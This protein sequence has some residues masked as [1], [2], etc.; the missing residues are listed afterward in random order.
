MSSPL[1]SP[2][3]HPPDQEADPPTHHPESPETQTLA[4]EA[5]PSRSDGDSQILV[6][7]DDSTQDQPDPVPAPSPSP[8]AQDPSFMAFASSRRRGGPKSKKAVQKRRA[9]A[10]K[11][12]QKLELLVKTFKPVPFAPGKV[13]DF[14]RREGLLQRLGLWEFV[15]LDFDRPLRG[16]LIAQLVASFSKIERCSYVNGVKIRVSRADLARALKLPAKRVV[17]SAEGAGEGSETEESI[18]FVLDL[19]SNW[20]LLHDDDT[21]MM[22]D[23]IMSWDKLIR[24]GSFEKVDWAGM[25]WFMVEK[26]LMLAPNLENCY[27]A[28][29]LQCLIRSQREELLSAVEVEVKD[30]EEVEVKDVD[31]VEVKDLE[32]V[33][34]KDAEE[35]G[36]KDVE[37]DADGGD[38]KMAELEEQ[39]LELSL[40]QEIANN[41]ADEEEKEGNKA[42]EEEKEGASIELGLLQNEKFDVENEDN[43]QLSLGLE[44]KVEAEM[45]DKNEV[46]L[47]EEKGFEME[48]ENK[49]EGGFD[50]VVDSQECKEEEEEQGGQYISG[51]PFL[52]RCSFNEAN[53]MRFDVDQKGGV[54]GEG[55]VG[56]EQE[57]EELEEEEEEEETNEEEQQEPG[58][59]NISPKFSDLERLPS[60]N[61]LHVLESA[62]IPFNTGMQLRDDSCGEFLASR[63]DSHLG[64]SSSSIFGNVNK[65]EI[66]TD[67]DRMHHQLNGGNKRMRTD[68]SWDSKSLDFNM[69]LEQVQHW[70]EKARMA[71]EAKEQAFAESGMNQQIFLSELQ[72]R[73]ALIEHLQKTSSEEI[74]KKKMEI[75]R[76]E[77]ELYMMANLLDGYKKAL[78]ETDRKFAEYRARC[79]QLDEPLYKD[80]PGSG[81]LVLSIRELEKQRLKQEEEE[82]MKLSAMK[83]KIEEFEN[84]FTVSFKERLE[85]IN[86]LNGRLHNVEKGLERLKESAEKRKASEAT[87]AIASREENVPEKTTTA[88]AA[89]MEE[90]VP[91]EATTEAAAPMEE[92]VPEE[93]TTEAAAPMEENVP[94]EATTTAPMEEN[95]PEEATTAAAAPMEENVPEE[96]TTAAA[97]PMEENVPEEATTAAAA[98]TEENVPEEA[99]TAAAAPMEEN[100]P[101]EAITAAAAPTEENVPEEAI[102][103]AAAPT[104]ENVPEEAITAA[105]APTEENVPEEAI[106]A[107]AAPTE[108]NVLE[109]ATTAAAAPTEENVPEEAATAAAAPTEE[110]LS[111]AAT[112][113]DPMEE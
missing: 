60:S 101:E 106:T 86:L 22:P 11:S 16:G 5:D 95:V 18:G 90:N 98:P 6:Q 2:L 54:E 25:M 82:K 53:E 70:V 45:D 31:E 65:R 61:L 97:A 87:I 72:R 81:G 49:E 94:E 20:M 38:V 34:V 48:K 55:V 100:V 64:P 88:A 69:C 32:E 56:E 66:D 103:A 109:E 57:D 76:L 12:Q 41:K 36:V 3:R 17:A 40:G 85:G 39:R 1:A 42:D 8:R 58:G 105:A 46:G 10:K 111:E 26:E 84:V 23:E 44:E 59:F 35:V 4:L 14:A 67:N 107:A 96:A 75:Y 7:D 93:A 77:C 80:V 21:W 108:E 37:E 79:P 104:E 99:T 24:E 29:H 73:D 9:M 62:H 30:V 78:K 19:V 27:Y 112:T 74:V 63:A 110:K 91:E 15:R 83:D 89:P 102:T 113:G 28:S 50:D 43:A 68:G 92:N 71:H 52:H 51:D 47:V 33:G 13:L